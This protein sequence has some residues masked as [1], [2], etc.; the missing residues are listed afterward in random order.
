M[1]VDIDVHHND[2]K[3]KRTMLDRYQEKYEY[4]RSTYT[5]NKDVLEYL[6]HLKFTRP[7]DCKRRAW[8]EEIQNVVLDIRQVETCGLILTLCPIERYKQGQL[9]DA[10]DHRLNGYGRLDPYVWV[11]VNFNRGTNQACAEGLC[12]VVNRW[13]Q[14]LI[15][16]GKAIKFHGKFKTAEEYLAEDN[17]DD[18]F[19]ET[20]RHLRILKSGG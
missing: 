7:N 16:E 17:E 14:E 15:D 12:E 13:N 11:H 9:P 1:N 18:G 8:Q 3:E 5:F 2:C 10:N 6:L 19:K 4:I 20:P